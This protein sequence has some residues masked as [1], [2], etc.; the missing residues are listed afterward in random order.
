MRLAGRLTVHAGVALTLSAPTLVRIGGR[1]VIGFVTSGSVEPGDLLIA[2]W[3]IPFPGTG[4]STACARELSRSSLNGHTGQ[5]SVKGVT[6]RNTN[7][8]AMN[9]LSAI[10]RYFTRTPRTTTLQ[11]LTGSPR[12]RSSS[13][14]QA[15]S[16]MRFTSGKWILISLAA[17]SAACRDVACRRI[18]PRPSAKACLFGARVASTASGPSTQR[19]S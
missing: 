16:P 17:A 13:T 8:P 7:N 10:H 2:D 1:S 9:L 18:R 14:V 11:T 3:T 6:M 19:G 15:G 12:P 5:G 4:G